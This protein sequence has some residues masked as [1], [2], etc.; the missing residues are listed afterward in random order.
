[1]PERAR[2]IAGARFRGAR[3]LLPPVIF[4]VYLTPLWIF[5]GVSYSPSNFPA[6][7][8]TWGKIFPGRVY[9]RA[10]R[11]TPLLQRTY[12]TRAK[13]FLPFLHEKRKFRNN[14]A[15]NLLQTCLTFGLTWDYL[16]TNL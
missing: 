4:R 2:Q 7:Y 13:I 8:L 6:H 9:V 12:R 14:F 1:M 3:T 10:M 16:G 5:P 15:K 11:E